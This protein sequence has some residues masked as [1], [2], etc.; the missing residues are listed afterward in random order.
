M[1]QRRRLQHDDEELNGLTSSLQRK[2]DVATRER[3]HHEQ[4]APNGVIS[5]HYLAGSCATCNRPLGVPVRLSDFIEANIEP[6]L[7]EWVAF[8]Q[9]QSG[10]DGM[11]ITALRDH[12]ADMLR[13]IAT[14]LRT[15]QSSDERF[16][17]SQGEALSVAG[18]TTAAESH[19]VGRAS[20][21][22]SVSEM[23]AEFR[24][25]RASVLHL[26]T[27]SRV[28]LSGHDVLDLM[29]FNEAIDQ[30]LAESVAQYTGTV[31]QSQAMFVAILGH[32]LRTPLHTV[33]LVTEHVLDA[34]LLDAQNAQLMM[35][36]LRSTKRMG[37]MI[38]DL[39]DFTRSRMGA[40]VAIDPHDID[41]AV[42][43]TEAAEEMRSAYPHH[44]FEVHLAGDLRGC[45]DGPRITQVLVNLLG[46]AV[47]HGDPKAPVLV[48][49]TGEANEVVLEV[50]NRGPAIPP[51]EMRGLFSPFKRLG[52]S[53]NA[54]DT[55][56]L[57]LGLY[58]VD[59][60]V[61]AHGGR[62]SVTSSEHAGTCF[63]AHLP[64]GKV[65]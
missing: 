29:R 49:A 2:H 22:F 55:H 62:I 31:D 43:L 8:A 17:K 33:S 65:A 21:G 23:M 40:G 63:S 18:E 20:S 5:V 13:T 14:D 54:S 47:Q 64:R 36:A 51:Q 52:R 32:D 10:A 50:R 41:L 12:A 56:H 15:P 61:T 26:W 4:L 59:Q 60:I 58:I 34:K 45:W 44:A 25:L 48:S 11:D 28:T 9:K 24:A 46:N 35:R 39:L 38:D 30:A 16:I 57:G 42:V 19:G 53:A 6:I 1:Q 3:P 37:R 27:Q 7:G